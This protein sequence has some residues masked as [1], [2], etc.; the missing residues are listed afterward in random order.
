MLISIHQPD[1]VP[2]LGFFN[3]V[4]LSDMLVIGDH[5]HYRNK[6]YQNRN[7]IKTAKGA[8]WLTVPIEHDWG[9]PINKIRVLNRE[10]NGTFWNDHHL[11]LLKINYSKAPYYDKYIEIFEKIYRK[12]N[13]LLVDVNMDFMK[14]VFEIL[15]IDKPIV[16]TSE[17]SLS[18]TKTELIVEICNK[19]DADSYLSGMGGKNYMDENVLHENKIKL[20]FNKYDNP[21]YNQQ[22]MELGFIP[23]LS[24]IDLLFNHGDESMK[25]IESGFKGF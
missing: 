17:M 22:F 12:K 24:V 5:V 16:K 11:N 7:K 13:D 25:I 14:S 9:Q 1:F 8:S 4:R 23:F 18:K 10:Q 6:G 2:W 15:G 3:K 19:V 20:L 21:V